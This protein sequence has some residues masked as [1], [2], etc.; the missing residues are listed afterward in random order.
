[1]GG[2]GI[3]TAD[4]LKNL[5]ERYG[6]GATSLLLL[7]PPDGAF[8]FSPEQLCQIR[9]WYSVMRATE[10]E[11]QKTTST[12]DIK[13]PQGNESR[14]YYDNVLLLNCDHLPQ[15][16]DLRRM[17]ANLDSSPWAYVKEKSDRLPLLFSFTF[18]DSESPK[19]GSFDPHNL[20]SLKESFQNDLSPLISGSHSYWV[21]PADYQWYVQKGLKLA[22]FIN[23]GMLLFLLLAI[24]LNY[25]TWGSGGLFVV[26]LA[27]SG[28][29]VLGFKSL[30]HSPIDV[31]SSGLFLMIALSTLEDFTFLSVEQMN[32]RSW[33]KSIRT[34]LVPS[35][36]TSLTTIVGFLSLCTSDLALI[37]RFGLWSAVGALLEWVMLF[38]FLPCVLKLRKKR[39]AWVSEANSVT[40]KSF[41]RLNA[42][43]L[44]RRWAWLC[45]LIY[46][47]SIYAVFHLNLNDTLYDI[48]PA[49][50]NF[51][52]G[53]HQLSASKGWTA[54]VALLGDVP[55]P[56]GEFD[57]I[58]SSIT[59]DAELKNDVV[60]AEGSTAIIDWL[61]AQKTE[62]RDS[63][64]SDFHDAGL[65][66]DWIDDGDLQRATLYVREISVDSLQK[67]K[68]R[69][70]IL[71]G[72]RCHLGGDLVAFSDFA[73]LIPKTLVESMGTSLILVSLILAFLTLGLGKK[74][75]LGKI[76]L[77]SF[78][79][80][81]AM[82]VLIGLF[83]IP[84]DVLQ[85]IVASILVGLTGDNAV[86]YLF[87]SHGKNITHG[88]KARGVA[89]VQTSV[90]M[91]V[92][93]LF[94]LFSYFRPPKIFGL[95]LASGL[96][97]SLTGDLWLF[98]GL[99]G[100]KERA[101]EDG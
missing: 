41:N 97:L 77:T 36:F 80:P 91:A 30:M 54:S 6:T 76:L 27:M 29:W 87:A 69:V 8:S 64:V 78:W 83:R 66:S 10:T 79:G 34:M 47:L 17:K 59:L 3:R 62:S 11:L 50:H 9:H 60:A 82:P 75:Y 43:A 4:E 55:L 40:F 58:I 90:M 81:L 52:Q 72:G 31:M 38:C 68:K 16:S 74:E 84:M 88:I 63:I 65:F 28:I 15:E 13:W 67:I 19:F 39:S 35:F 5:R 100:A 14:S 98:K 99:I 86:Q 85:C 32:G 49:R 71:C 21:G 45:M 94:Y 61:A 93:A 26:T 1:M 96:I 51:T 20:D 12:F 101:G 37:R 95:I 57:G 2:E 70:D 22:S 73:S 33:Q 18:K 44:P 23:L 56:Q 7:Y 53:L 24:R 48:F 42:K 89:S 46:P 92:V 25:G